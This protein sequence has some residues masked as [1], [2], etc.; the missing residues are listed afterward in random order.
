MPLADFEKFA[1]KYGGWYRPSK[2]GSPADRFLG[3][4]QES[5]QREVKEDILPQFDNAEIE[6]INV[7]FGFLCSENPQAHVSCV[8]KTDCVGITVGFYH[9]LRDLVARI[10]SHDHCYLVGNKINYEPAD[11]TWSLNTTFPEMVENHARVGGRPDDLVMLETMAYQ[12]CR[13]IFHHEMCH[14]WNGH[15]RLSRAKLEEVSND[16]GISVRDFQHVLELDADARAVHQT[17][18][19]IAK[20]IAIDRNKYYFSFDESGIDVE[21]NVSFGV[22]LVYLSMRLLIYISGKDTFGPTHPNPVHRMIWVIEELLRSVTY[23]TNI[24]NPKLNYFIFN[25]VTLCETHFCRITGDNHLDIFDKS[26]LNEATTER[27]SILTAWDALL[28]HLKEQKRGMNL[29]QVVKL[30]DGEPTSQLNELDIIKANPIAMDKLLGTSVAHYI[31]RMTLFVA[32]IDVS[33]LSI[34]AHELIAFQS[35]VTNLNYL[36]DPAVWSISHAQTVGNWKNLLITARRIFA[37]LR[38]IANDGRNDDWYAAVFTAIFTDKI[39]YYIDQSVQIDDWDENR[40]IE[41]GQCNFHGQ[42]GS[43]VFSSFLKDFELNGAIVPINFDL[44]F[45]DLKND[46]SNPQN[47]FLI[48]YNF[49]QLLLQS[50]QMAAIRT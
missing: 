42:D 24:S 38:G 20:Y 48:F 15:I 22:F 19:L 18:N 14:V 47:A 28:P 26:R 7:Q 8:D 6:G 35:E 2:D 12:G 41:L 50:I 29:P 4:I 39:L 1:R 32:N 5:I 36:A 10:F 9:V 11:E 34:S 16:T 3:F 43:P 33:K 30:G 25:A 37:V 13:F 45:N 17:M 44:P 49:V 46:L 23:K 21:R 27:A 40:Y 31:F